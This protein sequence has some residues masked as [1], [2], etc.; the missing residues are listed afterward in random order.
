MDLHNSTAFNA[1]NYPIMYSVYD[2][3]YIRFVTNQPQMSQVEYNSE[4]SHHTNHKVQ[5]FYKKF[6]DT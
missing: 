2:S 6:Y 3:E 1:S 5:D 4:F